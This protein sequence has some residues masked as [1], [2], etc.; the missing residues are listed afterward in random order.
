M[1]GVN[2]ENEVAESI[3]EDY[4]LF[5]RESSDSGLLEEIVHKFLPKTKPK[6]RE[7][8]V[9]QESVNIPESIPQPKFDH[10]VVSGYD[11]SRM[12][13]PKMEEGYGVSYAPP[14]QQYD[15]LN[16]FNR[17]QSISMERENQ[18]MMNYFAECPNFED[19]LHYPELLKSFAARMQ[20]A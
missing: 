7:T 3:D 8:L 14:M 6:S 11:D 20:N 19:F 4:E 13:V 1:V 9:K 12:R 5:P 16:G 17:M 15:T 2:H 18:L 10:M